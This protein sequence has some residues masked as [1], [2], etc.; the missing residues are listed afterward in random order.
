LARTGSTWTCSASTDGSTFTQVNQF[1]QLL[2]IT[3]VGPWAGNLGGPFTAYVDYFTPYSS[4]PPSGFQSD[5][6][7]GATLNSFWTKNDLVGDGSLSVSNGQLH[8]AVPSGQDHD[9]YTTGNGGVEVFQS[10]S[11]TSF[12]IEAKF[13]STLLDGSTQ[14]LMAW[15]DDAHFIRCD[16]GMN[17]DGVF[18]YSAYINGASADHEVIGSRDPGPS[19]WL[20]LS[21]QSDTWTCS[22]STDGTAFDILNQ[23]TQALT[24]NKVGPWAGNLGSAF[25]ALVDYVQPVAGP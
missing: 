5:Q 24:V 22:V 15:Q 14:G 17:S 8:I 4:T 3:K 18:G 7:T 1:S 23:F 20:R 12:N 19:F 10:I 25:T 6:F 2:N 16:V 9:P 13:D 11:N 21:R